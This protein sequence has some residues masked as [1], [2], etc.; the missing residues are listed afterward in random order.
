MAP[1]FFLR[2]WFFW[3]WGISTWLPWCKTGKQGP[4]GPPHCFCEW[5][6]SGRAMPFGY[7]SFAL[8]PLGRVE[9]CETVG[10][11]TG[12]VYWGDPYPIPPH[13]AAPLLLGILCPLQ[14]HCPSSSSVVAATERL[15]S[16]A[17]G[18]AQGEPGWTSARSAALS[19]PGAT[20]PQ[21][22]PVKKD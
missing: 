15:V 8:A 21:P 19:A 13:L 11:L 12:D 18:V 22:L 16:R 5:S 6:L 3:F 2:F 14:W 1:W 10:S 9:P 4:A 7:G 17:G 20:L